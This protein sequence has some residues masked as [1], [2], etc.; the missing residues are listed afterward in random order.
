MHRVKSFCFVATTFLMTV[1]VVQAQQSTK[2]PRIGLLSGGGQTKQ[3]IQ[4]F[5]EGLKD[6]GYVEGENILI[7][8]RY[9]ERNVNE[10]PGLV[11]ELLKLKVDLLV[12]QPLLAIRAAKNATQTIPVVM[13]I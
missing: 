8:E 5:R 12:V 9:I 4:S 7:E 10:F 2:L 11:D 1:G 3:N 13:V 6:L